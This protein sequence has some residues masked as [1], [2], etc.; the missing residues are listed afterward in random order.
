MKEVGKVVFRGHLRKG[1]N[2]FKDRGHNIENRKKK[3]KGSNK[4][5]EI[6]LEQRIH[7]RKSTHTHTQAHKGILGGRHVRTLYA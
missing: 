5:A 3:R 2:I 7:A 1:N 6:K 4:A